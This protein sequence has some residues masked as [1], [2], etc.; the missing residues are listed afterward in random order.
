MTGK[1]Q[2]MVS[3]C[4]SE[5]LTPYPSTIFPLIYRDGKR[6]Q[7]F[8]YIAF[9]MLYCILHLLMLKIRSMHSYKLCMNTIV[10]LRCGSAIAHHHTP[11]IFFEECNFSTPKSGKMVPNAHLQ[12]TSPW[13]MPFVA[14]Q[15]FLKD[16]AWLWTSIR[17]EKYCVALKWNFLTCWVGVSRKTIQCE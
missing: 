2:D 3:S 10:L 6:F 5:V 8:P 17:E 4:T 16:K 1:S 15:T 12:H 11:K 9:N 14:E 13:D 7:A